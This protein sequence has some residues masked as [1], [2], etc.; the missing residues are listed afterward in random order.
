MVGNGR[1]AKWMVRD[2]VGGRA[3]GSTYG[4]RSH[5]KHVIMPCC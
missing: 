4:L 1:V 2:G 5:A 3:K